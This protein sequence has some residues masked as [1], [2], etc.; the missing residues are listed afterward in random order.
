MYLTI[1]S[2]TD[3][4][5]NGTEAGIMQ[6]GSM[7]ARDTQALVTAFLIFGIPHI[8][9]RSKAITAPARLPCSNVSQLHIDMPFPAQLQFD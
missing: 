5:S 6:H 7:A 2:Q 4:L 8:A 9:L 1:L 3:T